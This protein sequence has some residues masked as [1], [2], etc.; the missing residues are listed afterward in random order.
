[1]KKKREFGG[2]MISGVITT[3]VNYFLYA[4]L[5]ALNLPLLG[6]N[7]AAW[8]G[9]VLT[10]YV[11]NRRL[12]FH[13][14]GSVTGELAAFVSLRFITLLAENALLWILIIRLAFPAFPAKLVVSA[15]TVTGNYLLCKFGIFRKETVCHG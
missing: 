5:L 9:A 8:A 2:Y 7:S 11:L 3:A 12:V 13:S 10:A 4:A 15:V 14:K 6:A 1:M